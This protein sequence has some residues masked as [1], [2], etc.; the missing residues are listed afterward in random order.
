MRK[1]IFNLVALVALISLSTLAFAAPKHSP[2]DREMRELSAE[3]L[4]AIEGIA[5]AHQEKLYDL[6]EK[7]WAKQA[8]LQALCLSGKAEKSDIHGLIGDISALRNSMH[9]ERKAIRSEV[10]KQTGLKGFGPHDDETC[11]GMDF[12]G[13]GLERGIGMSRSGGY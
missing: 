2:R 13:R 11:T 6:R 1:N 3:K 12:H 10:E 9:Q 8:E 7:I 5:A 4:V